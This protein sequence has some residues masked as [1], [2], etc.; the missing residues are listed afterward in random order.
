[1]KRILGLALATLLVSLPGLWRP[2]PAA[3]CGGF[4]CQQV[5]ID[6]SG[7]YILFSI[8]GNGV[9]AYIQIQYQGA[10]ADFAWVVPVST[11]PRKVSVGVQQVF[12]TLM[13]GT[14]PQYRI[15]WTYTGGTCGGLLFPTGG[16]TQDA[17][18]SADAGGVNVIDKGEVG[19]YNYVVVSAAESAKLTKWLNDN[20]FAQPAS[21]QAA[22]D[23]YV[24]QNFVFVAIKL[25]R[26]AQ[27]GDIQPL[28]LD[29]GQQEACVPLVLTRIA[30]I[31]D[32]PIYAMVLGK[33][34]AVPRNW[35][36]VEV[37]PLR[38]DWFRNG[39]NYRQLVTD[40]INEAEGRAFVTEY[41]G[42]T[43]R[44]KGSLWSPGRYDL[45][46]LAGI[47]SPAQFVSI[48]LQLGLPR[49]PIIQSLLRKYIPMPQAVRDRGIS[50]AQFYN[51]LSTFQTDLAKQPFDGPGFMKEL[52]DRIVTPLQE[53]QAMIDGQPTLTR[54]FTT[55]SPDE[56]TR[57]PLFDFNPDLKPV[58]NIHTAQGT[59]T[60][61]T[62]GR[63][64]NATLTFEGGEKVTIAESFLP[65][66]PPVTLAF[67]QGQPAAARVQLIG[68]TGA[69]INI[70][71]ARIK[72]YD[73]RLDTMDVAAVRALAKAEE[74]P[75]PT[76]NKDGGTVDAAADGL[77]L[78][79]AGG[80][81]PAGGADKSSG[82]SCTVGRGSDG[83]GSFL[84]LV[85]LLALVRARR[86]A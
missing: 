17:A 18:A 33:Y 26:D 76:V 71:R 82:C 59:G 51:S 19:P 60:C 28:V 44:F 27:V 84:L 83:G 79:E 45:T 52:S 21:A 66:Q 4:F 70:T 25:K 57:D 75:E 68:P 12:T 3:A 62:D 55:V 85:G 54:L 13:N 81:V 50:E 15:N 14:V 56:M 2:R 16:S 65:Y 49:D 39:S 67:A 72:V 30:A 38:I 53:A 9:R 80:P 46:K 69:P 41:A 6:Q 64:S 48:M 37:N 36:Q 7:E 58:S 35:F 11:V 63:V 86:R 22:L 1:M 74:Q 34:R 47:T 31:P 61:G 32:M 24:K 42:D 43:T 5:P 29:M 10:A 77:T 20:G 78:G 8:D 73:Q 40:A 23:H